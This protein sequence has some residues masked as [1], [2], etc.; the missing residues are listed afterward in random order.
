MA[1][2]VSSRTVW[3]AV[4]QHCTREH[5]ATGDPMRIAAMVEQFASETNRDR[6]EA[7]HNEEKAATHPSPDTVV[8]SVTAMIHDA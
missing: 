1:V 7:A 3:F 8:W 2:S 5:I 6:W 4:C